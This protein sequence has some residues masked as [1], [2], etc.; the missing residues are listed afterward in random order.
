MKCGG[1]EKKFR[2][3]LKKVFPSNPLSYLGWLGILGILG[4]L[5]I[6][7]LSRFFY[8]LHSSLIGR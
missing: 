8:F 6:P 2:N 1:K 3:Y 5:F 7:V 4:I